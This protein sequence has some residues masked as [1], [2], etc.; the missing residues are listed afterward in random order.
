[1]ENL[2]H[3]AGE[4]FPVHDELAQSLGM[5]N[6]VH[7]VVGDGGLHLVG[8][9]E[10]RKHALRCIVAEADIPMAIDDNGGIGLL[11][12]QHE[13]QGLANIGYIFGRLFAVAIGRHEAGGHVQDIALLKW[14]IERHAEQLH[15]LA[16]WLRTAGFKK[17]QMPGRD[18]CLTC[19][20]KLAEPALLPPMPEQVAELAG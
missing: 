9:A 20:F 18:I 2:D 1:M 13:I 15:H 4:F 3:P 16:A 5:E 14:Q 10:N 12:A 8:L 19:Q 7:R 17:T 6:R 11:L